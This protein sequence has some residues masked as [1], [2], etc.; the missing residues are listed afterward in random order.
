VAATQS[1]IRD[2]PDEQ[3]ARLEA[4]L[5]EF[6]RSWTDT[7]FAS[8]ANELPVDDSWRTAAL[9]ELAKVD[10]E[11]QW[12][13]GRRVTVEEYLAAFPDLAVAGRAPADLLQAEYEARRQCGEA[14]AL[15]NLV[16]RFPAEADALRSLVASAVPP[17]VGQSTANIVA[18]TA[19]QDTVEERRSASEPGAPPERV[20]RYR[21]LRRL[22]KGGMGTVYLAHDDDLDRQVALKVPHFDANDGPAA[23]ERFRREARAA[24]TLRHPHVCPVYDVG[25]IN[26]TYYL[27]MAY[28]EGQSLAERLR[29]GPPLSEA[30]VADL[31]G[32]I[33]AALAAA[34]ERGIVHRDLKPANIMLGTD[35]VPYVM[36]F[37]LARRAGSDDAPLTQSGTV[38]GTPAYMSPEQVEGK[39]G[40]VGPASDVYSLGVILYELL[41]RRMPFRGSLTEVLWQVSFQEPEPPSALR[42]GLDP[43]LESVVMRAMAKKPEKRFRSMTEF[44]QALERRPRRAGERDVT[45][46]PPRP[47]RRWW[48]ALAAFGGLALVLGGI[49]ITV[50]GPDGKER[51]IEVPDNGPARVEVGDGKG[52]SVGLTI[53]KTPAPVVPPLPDNGEPEVAV[54]KG[55]QG[56]VWEV[57]FLADGTLISAGRDGRL[58][59]WDVAKKAEIGSV[60]QSDGPNS[61]WFALSP[62]GQTLATFDNF[63]TRTVKLWNPSTREPVATIPHSTDAVA[64]SLDSKRLAAAGSKDVKVWRI[65][66]GKELRKIEGHSDVVTAVAFSPDGSLLATGSSDRTVKL[67]D[68]A[69]GARRATIQGYGGG[70]DMVAFSE[71]GKTLLSAADYTMKFWDVAAGKETNSA[72]VGSYHGASPDRQLLFFREA[73]D[74]STLKPRPGLPNGGERLAVSPDGVHAAAAK[75]AAVWVWSAKNHAYRAKLS[76]HTAKVH[77]RAFSPDGKLLA[78]ASD[79]GTIRLWDVGKA[80]NQNL[81]VKE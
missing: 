5:I 56:A 57:Q 81:D 14:N 33:A 25:E 20:G 26:G 76:E 3:R 7:L 30:E 42:P 78:S 66:E 21:I 6:E 13:R 31:V 55:H 58:R 12:A 10:L 74:R 17:T 27:T 19:R 65:P 73:W 72:R 9:V 61:W 43:Q 64:F 48:P 36:D 38:L 15:T 39:P 68:A 54:L 46:A 51:P 77:G 67:W 44:A 41:T 70:V 75:G 71:D 32:R 45:A 80:I 28:I 50:R 53:A 60:K 49:I 79:D 11:R 63:D 34:H 22:G 62:D 37:G 47:P 69:S 1:Q 52:G 59:F 40:A 8:W 29:A 2:L 24:A 35:G 4:R 23:L 18:A 16:D